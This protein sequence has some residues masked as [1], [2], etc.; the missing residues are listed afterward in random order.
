MSSRCEHDNPR[1]R[2]PQCAVSPWEK[3]CKAQADEIERLEKEVE[4]LQ[5]MLDDVHQMLAG[6]H[7]VNQRIE[8]P[9]TF[10]QRNLKAMKR[11]GGTE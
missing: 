9:D 6:G 11:I 2:C 1:Y 4:R 10:E 3:R 5:T 8:Y 7:F